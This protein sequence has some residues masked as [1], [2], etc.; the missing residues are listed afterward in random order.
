M[1]AVAIPTSSVPPRSDFFPDS[2]DALSDIRGRYRVSEELIDLGSRSVTMFRVEDTN[3]LLDTIDPVTFAVDE[4]L[5]YWAELWPSSLELARYC[6]SEAT[7]YNKNVLELGC[8]LGLAGIAA[9]AA[10]ARVI[11]TDY[12][13]DAL[14]F[15]RL[16]AWENLDAD[17]RR[18]GIE[19]RLLD[20]RSVGNSDRV[21]MIIGADVAY[22][23]AQFSPLL[24][25]VRRFLK[26][27]GCA[28]FTDPDRSTGMSFFALAEREG[29]EV[30]LTSRPLRYKGKTSTILLGLLRLP[31]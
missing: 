17:V 2:P 1:A 5:P 28:V 3:A 26:D 13:P 15:A 19:F 27:N 31:Q 4:R 23:R 30:T 6:L 11:F 20:W 25:F 22:E 29:F 9:A 8:G 7:L 12:E 10:G 16:N 14:R 21:D 24:G 18:S